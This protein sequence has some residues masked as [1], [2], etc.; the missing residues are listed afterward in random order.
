MLCSINIT[1]WFVSTYAIDRDSFQL[2]VWEI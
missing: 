2:F 1:V